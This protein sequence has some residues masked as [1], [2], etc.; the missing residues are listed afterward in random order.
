MEFL[1]LVVIIY[2]IIKYGGELLT[3]IIISIIGKDR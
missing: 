2:I 1:S 3:A